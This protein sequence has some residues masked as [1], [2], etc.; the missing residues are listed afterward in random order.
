VN[1]VTLDFETFFS[2]TYTLTRGKHQHT[3]EHYV[4]DPRFEVH[5]C[6]VK[7]SWNAPA[8]WMPGGPNLAP[9][10]CSIDW[11]NTACLAHHA[12]FDGLILAHHYGIRPARWLDTLSMARQKLGNHLSV[13]L[14]NVRLHYG[15]PVKRTPYDL[16]RNKHWNELT[17]DVQDLIADGCCDEVESIWHLFANHLMPGFPLALLPWIDNTVRMFTEPKLVGDIDTLADLWRSEVNH[18][19]Q[20][21][22]RLGVSA[23]DLG[24]DETF[25]NLL[26]AVGCEPESKTT[27]KG[28]VK[29]AFAKT[30]PF[31]QDIVEDEDD[32]VRALAEARLAVKSA[33]QQTRA[34]RLG[35]MASRGAMCV[36]ISAFGAHTNRDSGGDKVN[37][38]N[39]T[40]GSQLGK[41][42]KTPKGSL[43]ATVDKSQI[44]CR[45]LNV[46]AGQWDVVE[47]FRQKLDPYTGIASQFYGHEVYKPA[48]GD[49]RQEEM[50]T[51]RGTGKQLELS[52]GYGAGGPTIVHTARKG[53]YG[54]PVYLTDQQGE[55]AKYLYRN[56][57]PAI[58]GKGTG[59]WAQ[60]GRMISAIAGTNQPIKWG[61]VEVRTGHI[62]GPDGSM[63]R[64]PDLHYDTDREE[65]VYKRRHGYTKLYGG[66]LTE[67]LIQWLAWIAFY[68][69]ICRIGR[70]TGLWP[71]IREHDKGVWSIP[72]D[73][74]AEQTL[75]YLKREMSRPPAWMPDIP[76]DCDASLS[77]P[78]DSL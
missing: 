23:K 24:S 19:A 16:F 45:I 51:K 62:L 30:D 73:Q 66:K 28:N 31:M 65:W 9:F 67:N 46:F 49:P 75:D 27:A 3:T 13:S 7:E 8:Q 2:D 48:K 54:P 58:A 6:S 74:Y 35:F 22:A 52:C 57:H 14:D 21:L 34:E 71:S 33:L 72:D 59:L 40:R 25:A 47:R 11:A 18:K 17:P 32:D 12:Q 38:Q 60:A 41:S 61:C 43:K 68:Q 20:L 10:L 64:Y 63:L 5:G 29:Y 77:E 76:L 69:D 56:T 37:W 15:M 50:E 26:R 78:G 44:E 36:Y 70:E 42:V 1:I 39:F 55:D 53:T 4:R